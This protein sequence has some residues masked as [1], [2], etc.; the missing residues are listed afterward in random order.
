MKRIILTLLLVAG[1]I[2]TPMFAQ[3]RMDIGFDIPRGVGAVLDGQAQISAEASNA[4]SSYILPF[5][6]V[7][8]YYQHEFSGV[9]IRVGGGLRCF[10]FIVESVVWPNVYVEADVWKFTFS[11]QAGGGIF[12]TFGLYNSLNTANVIIP[13]L[14]AWFRIGKNFR[15]GG[16]AMVFVSPELKDSAAFV[17]YLGMKFAIPF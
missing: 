17:Y 3:V 7:G 15:V 4:L 2:A 9:P 12:G 16:G 5:P 11:L 13:D 10:T 14:S 1:L 8:V 6:E